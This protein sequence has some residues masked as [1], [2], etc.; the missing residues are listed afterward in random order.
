[1][2]NCDSSRSVRPYRTDLLAHYLKPDRCS[3]HRSTQDDYYE[4]YFVPKGSIVIANAWELNHDP[5]VYGADVHEFN[6]ARHLDASGNLLPGPPGSK[7]EGHFTFGVYSSDIAGGYQCTD[8][9]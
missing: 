5:D 7:D 2:V 6:P 3:P 1:M 4:G 9:Q 8:L